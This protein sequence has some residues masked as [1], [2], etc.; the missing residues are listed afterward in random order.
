MELDGVARLG[1]L[2]RTCMVNSLYGVT[3]ALIRWLKREGNYK[4]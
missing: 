4:L 3:I 2:T 1:L